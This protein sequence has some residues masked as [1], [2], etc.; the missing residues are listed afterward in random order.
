[1]EEVSLGG[2]V[3]DEEMSLDD[4]ESGL[5]DEGATNIQSRKQSQPDVQNKEEVMNWYEDEEL[6]MLDDPDY[7]PKFFRDEND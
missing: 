7:C 6:K 2:K 4:E 5:K 1:M 3:G